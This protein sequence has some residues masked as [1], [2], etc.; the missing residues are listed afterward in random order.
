MSWITSVIFSLL[1]NFPPPSVF[2][3]KVKEK[4]NLEAKAKAKLKAN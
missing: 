4:V 3:G 2:E 1:D